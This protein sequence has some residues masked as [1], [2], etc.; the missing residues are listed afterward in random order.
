MLVTPSAVSLL[1]WLM[2]T[3][4]FHAIETIASQTKVGVQTSSEVL[5]AVAQLNWM[6]TNSF[7]RNGNIS[8]L[9]SLTFLDIV[10]VVGL[11]FQ[12]S[13]KKIPLLTRP[14]VRKD[15]FIRV[16]H[17][18][19]VEGLKRISSEKSHQQIKPPASELQIMFSNYKQTKQTRF[20]MVQGP[21]V[22]S[23]VK[24]SQDQRQ[25]LT[26][27]CGQTIQISVKPVCPT[28]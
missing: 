18:L 8:K 13:V 6:V 10:V 20:V 9:R 22:Q 1:L 19:A 25:F 4:P 28:F 23:R 26:P 2:T 17:F 15:N 12:R 14:V 16:R 24:L 7:H 5:I 21:V 27:F 11:F 3:F